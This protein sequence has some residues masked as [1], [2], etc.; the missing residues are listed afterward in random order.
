[1]VASLA[2]KPL[3]PSTM[4]RS[5]T[6]AHRTGLAKSMSGSPVKETERRSIGHAL[7]TAARSKA[8]PAKAATVVPPASVK[9]STNRQSDVDCAAISMRPKV[10]V[11]EDSQLVPSRTFTKDAAP[12]RKLSQFT[13]T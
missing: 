9:T 12:P 4:A 7:N 6:G 1:M 5:G 3:P 8:Q 11:G 13:I 2:T 10:I